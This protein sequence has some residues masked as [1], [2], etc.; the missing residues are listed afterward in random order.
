MGRTRDDMEG[1]TK[2]KAVEVPR[3]IV[4]GHGVLDGVREICEG[5]H[6]HGPATIITGG[7]TSM[8]AG[9]KVRDL[10]DGYDIDICEVGDATAE[11]AHAAA[12][13]ARE[14][15]SSFLL[16]VGGGSKI[17]LAKVV[18][19]ELHVPFLSVPTSAAHDGIAS[20]RAS[21]KSAN[22]SRSVA[23]AS[24]IAVIADTEIIYKAPYRLLAAG[25][26][27]V[28]SNITAVKDWEFARRL[29]GEQV[30]RSAMFLAEHA[31]DDIIYSSK[32]IRPGM[33]ESVWMAIKPIIM[34]GLS[35]SI[36]GSSRPTSGAEH[37]I[38]HM[39]DLTCPGRALHG[40]QCGVGSIMTMY[41]HGGDWQR[42]RDALY[43]IGAPTTAKELN[44]APDELIYA[45]S[46]ATEIRQDRFT[47]LGD[48][49]ISPEVAEAAAKATG[50]I[51]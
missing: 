35:M 38:S 2:I 6:L 4:A 15:G 20:N 22:G 48:N 28:I 9:N 46:H 44:I 30:S 1:F 40:E 26:A 42:I 27:D 49:G 21:L 45:M 14:F 29:K 13:Q 18:S 8:I 33:E 12:E 43:N 37:M 31:A 51:R 47:I 25:C 50:V 3:N 32:D 39:L 5:L 17:D 19:N 36:A 34:S 16:A 41:L 23:S 10:L 7:K 11:N 24:P